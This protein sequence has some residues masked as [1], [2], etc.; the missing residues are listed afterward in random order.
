MSV[1]AK[2]PVTVFNAERSCTIVKAS[3]VEVCY[4]VPADRKRTTAKVGGFKKRRDPW[5]Q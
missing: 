2:N 5:N 1:T 4:D 3:A